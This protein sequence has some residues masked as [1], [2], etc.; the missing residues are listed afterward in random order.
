MPADAGVEARIVEL[1]QHQHGVVTRQQL[2]Q[3]GLTR[4]V[5]AR[6]VREQRLRPMQRGVYLLGAV[7]PS[8]AIEMAAL[9][10]CGVRA[11]L[12]HWSAARVWELALPGDGATTGRTAGACAIGT[13][14]SP[15][16]TG[17]LGGTGGPG[18]PGGPGGTVVDVIVPLTGGGRRPGVRAYR[19]ASLHPGDVRRVHGMPV[20]APARTV[21]DLATPL[22][23][24]RATRQLEQLVAEV[25]DRRLATE[26]EL[27]A[28]VAR[29][30][31]HKGAGLLRLLLT[32]GAEPMFVRSEAEER[33]LQ[34]VRAAGLP[35]PRTNVRVSGHE[36]DMFWKAER[37]IV[38]VDGHRWHSSRNRFERD[39]ARD[40]DLAAAGF[41]VL[42][43]T[44]RQ[45]D[46]E[47][48]RVVGR[49]AFMLGRL[50]LR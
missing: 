24:A 5:V 39:R 35:L 27:Q 26:E 43:F 47:P 16:G 33:L 41:I 38:E 23:R 19:T 45:I 1:A 14:G 3:A 28:V 15:G 4:R 29:N 6:R 46:D 34:L 21:F 25:L 12:S 18:G 13:P 17:G 32:S 11:V 9:L 40:A 36:V 8:W 48:D 10:A 20:T 31:S 7:M 30:A 50:S 44:W 22:G 49:I 42:R 2:L 37:L